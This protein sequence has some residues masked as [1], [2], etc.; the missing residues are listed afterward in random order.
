MRDK[1]L[2][3]DS[4]YEE[5]RITPRLRSGVLPSAGI[6][7]LDG[8]Y[9]VEVYGGAAQA[10]LQQAGAILV[11]SVVF[12]GSHAERPMRG[13][14]ALELYP[15]AELAK[16]GNRRLVESIGWAPIGN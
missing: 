5:R 9:H 1:E 14:A 13:V 8:G 15:A 6:W 3:P 10:R 11:A 7:L 12:D 16:A 2:L 4:Y